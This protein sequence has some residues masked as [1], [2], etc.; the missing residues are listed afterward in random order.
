MNGARSDQSNVTVDGIAVND[1]GGHA[2]TSVLPVTLDSV[3]EFRV[4]TTNAN[5]DQGGSGGAQVA[6]VTKSGTNQFHGSA[7]EYNRNTFTSANDYFIKGSELQ[8]GEPNKAP[9]L[10]RNI[11]GGSVGGPIKKDRLYFFLNYEG[12]RRIEATSEN[13]VVPSNALRDGVIYYQCDSSSPTVAS[14]C[15]GGSVAGLSGNTYNIPAPVQNADGSISAFNALSSDQLKKIDPLGIGANSAALAYMQSLPKPNTTNNGDGLNYQGYIFS[16]P[17]SDTKNEYIAKVDYNLTAD[18]K[19]RISV[20]GALRN[21]NNAGAPF[22]PG[23]APSQAIVNYN[24]GIIVNYSGVIRTSLVNNFRYGF[25]RESSGTIGNS[26][27]QWV[28][29]RGLSDQAGA[30][31]RTRS[32]QRPTNVFADDLTWIHGK[33]SWQFGGQIAL[34]RNPR[35]STVSSFSSGSTNAGWMDTTGYAGKS[36]S[37]LNPAN[38]LNPETNTPYPGVDANFFN[39][40]DFPL[41]ALMGMV[42]EVN[43]QYNYQRDG[44]ALDQG[45]PLKRRFALNSY[46]MYAQD[47]WKVKPTFTLTLG[48]RYSIFLPPWETNKLEVSP[49]F[50]LGNWFANRANEGAN[51]IPSNQDQPVAFNWSGRANGQ[52]GF[53]NTDWKNFGPRFAFAWAPNQSEGL[54]GS[55]F[56]RENIDSR[57]IRHGLRSIWAGTGG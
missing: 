56:G 45:A 24:K 55:L 51:G 2:F 22:Y 43:A 19:H 13:H 52:G 32:F 54:L 20:S 9:K 53:Y 49:T 11:F 31:T 39:S 34:V 14:D 18:A 27:Q 16:G 48:L 21:E 57:R 3:Q 6:L 17:I 36:G 28:Y 35:I 15:P 10:I 5:A 41:T 26:D 29:F 4:T 47:T 30:V 1:E 50:N 42:S 38:N 46:E 8:N 37:P 25:I 44:S 40:Y 7:Y 33:H 23:E 12:T